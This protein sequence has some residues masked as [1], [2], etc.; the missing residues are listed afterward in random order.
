VES[1]NKPGW[2]GR[3]REHILEYHGLLTGTMELNESIC[4]A[5]EAPGMIPAAMNLLFWNSLL[6]LYASSTP[7]LLKTK[8]VPL[9]RQADET[10]QTDRRRTFTASTVLSTSSSGRGNSYIPSPRRSCSIGSTSSDNCWW[11][12]RSL[13]GFAPHNRYNSLILADKLPSLTQ[14]AGPARA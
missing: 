14:Y 3:F 7:D 12:P 6:L 10:E 9:Y 4:I 2:T 1:G 5:C 13:L 8:I 11:P